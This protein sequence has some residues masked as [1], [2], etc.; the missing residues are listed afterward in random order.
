M[1]IIL[2]TKDVQEIIGEWA[3]NKLEFNCA[4]DMGVFYE[5]TLT[6]V[7]K[8]KPEHQPLEDSTEVSNEH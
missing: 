6:A 2:Y 3:K 1:K 7:A 5:A 4:V 8:P